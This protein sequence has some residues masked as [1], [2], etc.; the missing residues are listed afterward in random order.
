MAVAERRLEDHER[1][2]TLARERWHAAQSDRATLGM[3]VHEFADLKGALNEIAARA[4]H[5]AV[6]EILDRRTAEERGAWRARAQW[7]AIGVSVAGVGLYI[8]EMLRPG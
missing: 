2:H 6:T 4:A 3:L 8:L 5:Q 1:E 7:T